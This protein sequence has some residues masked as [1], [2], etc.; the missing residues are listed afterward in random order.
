MFAQHLLI[1][2]WF[3]AKK[4]DVVG[5]PF[6]YIFRSATALRIGNASINSNDYEILQQGLNEVIKALYFDPYS[7][8]LL[9]LAMII[10]LRLDNVKEAQKYYDVFKLVAKKSYLITS[11]NLSKP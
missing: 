3:Y 5:Y 1:A 6:A 2:E 4:I 9:A 7:G 11:I 8:E 10:N